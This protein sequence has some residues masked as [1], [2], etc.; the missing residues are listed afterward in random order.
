MKMLA[1]LAIAMMVSTAPALAVPGFVFKYECKAPADS[2]FST[3]NIAIALTMVDDNHARPSHFVSATHT[4]TSGVTYDVAD[5]YTNYQTGKVIEWG[6]PYWQA[7][8]KKVTVFAGF[9]TTDKEYIYKVVYSKDIGHGK[10]EKIKE[11]ESTCNQV[12]P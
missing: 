7:K 1:T 9:E 12:S 6:M 10:F 5:K 2:D 4:T 3:A 11:I 8:D